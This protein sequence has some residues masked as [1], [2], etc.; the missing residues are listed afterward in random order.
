MSLG[1]HLIEL[2]NRLFLSAGA[3]L[4]GAIGGW[5]LSK[6]VLATMRIPIEELRGTKQA[7]IIYDTVS[8]AFDLK[9]QIAFTVGI[10]ITSPF[11]LY[12]IGAFLLPGLT[13]R[14]KGYFLGF[15]F[16]AVPLFIAGGYLGWSIF[17]RTVLL[18][19]GFASEQDS[20]NLNAKYYYDFVI[21]FVLFCGV[22]FVL[23][24]LI[25]LL[26]FLTLLSAKSIIKGWRVA[27]LVIVIFTSLATPAGD[28]F[29]MVILAVPMVL[30]YAAAA[31]V[32][33]IHDRAAARRADAIDSELASS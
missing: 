9:I 6:W 3:I 1:Q 25:V 17:P 5:F 32:A 16:A 14:E 12:Q 19:A 33:W 20:T 31:V 7:A 27:I 28:I 11:W 15:F 8:G 26:N 4:L 2:R 21:K 10:V 23:P 22:A 13:R 24:V 29:T 30:L 18:L